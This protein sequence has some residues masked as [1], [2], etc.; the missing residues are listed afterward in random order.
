MTIGRA[1]AQHRAPMNL[2]FIFISTRTRSKMD[3]SWQ[4][5]SD[6]QTDGR[7][8]DDQQETM[9]DC[10]H[11]AESRALGVCLPITSGVAQLLNNE[12]TWV[13]LLRRCVLKRIINY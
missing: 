7:K 1:Y 13:S 5:Q 8:V 10:R 11:P 2:H 12:A 4:R 3:K 9:E 6:R